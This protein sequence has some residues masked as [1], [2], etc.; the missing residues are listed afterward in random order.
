MFDYI[1]MD[2]DDEVKIAS[3]WFQAEV[4]WY[5]I[6]SSSWWTVSYWHGDWVTLVGPYVKDRLF[7][8]W[9]SDIGF[10]QLLLNSG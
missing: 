10:E 4:G 2:M 8:V 5:N 3:L 9:E 7:A 6:L 1:Y